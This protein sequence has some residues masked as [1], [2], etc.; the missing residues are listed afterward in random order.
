M[1]KAC[2]CGSS[3]ASQACAASLPKPSKNKTRRSRSPHSLG[4][5]PLVCRDSLEKRRGQG[6]RKLFRSSAP[7]DHRYT[8]ALLKKG[9][10]L[11]AVASP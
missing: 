8:Q 2:G 10:G 7:K 3:F 6:S 11:R 1:A 9:V 5:L 4:P